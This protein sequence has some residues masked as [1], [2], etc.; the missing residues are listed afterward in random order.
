MSIKQTIVG[1][2]ALLACF[3][4]QAQLVIEITKG[5][6]NAI[7]IAIVPFGW[8]GAAALPEDVAGVVS[9]DLQRSGRFAPLARR[10]IDPIGRPTAGA[11]IRFQDWRY[12]RADYVAVGRVA[13]EAGGGYTVKFELHSVLN[14]RKLLDPPPLRVSATGLRAAA[15]RVRPCR[16][17]CA[18]SYLQLDR[19]RRGRRQRVDRRI[20]ERADHVA[21]VVTGRSECGVC[22]V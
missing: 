6:A 11:D 13:S 7:P 20:Q 1:F 3:A 5:Q 4:A 14:G 9:A 12:V 2:V 8:S 10:D 15:H 22:V 21:R 18:T 19:C 16:R 17:R